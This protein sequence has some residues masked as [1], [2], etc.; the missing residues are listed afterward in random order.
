[1]KDPFDDA[2]LES[3]L[4]YLR[5]T[6]SLDFTGYKRPSLTR[7]IRK[8]IDAVGVDG[9]DEY[10][11]VLESDPDEQA[12]L[13]DTILINVTA[14]FRDEAAW[15]F[16]SAHVV[17]NILAA[18][19]A[20][21]PIRVWSAGCASGEEAYSLAMLLADHLGVEEFKARVKIFATDTDE[22][23]L[24]TARRGVYT[25]RQLEPV[26]PERRARYFEPSPDGFVFRSDC[27]RQVIFGHN[28]ITADAPISRLDLLV[29]RNV[30]MYLLSDTQ[31]HVLDRFSYALKPNGYLFL[32]KAET[33]TAHA[34]LFDPV[35]T[36]LRVF[37]RASTDRPL[38]VPALAE[39]VGSPEM[40][41]DLALA[42]TPVAQLV[43]DVDG[44]VSGANTKARAMFGVS[45]DYLDRP[46]SELEVAH[47]PVELRPYVEQA[48]AERRPVVLR[49]VSRTLADG[50]EQFLE[51]SIAPLSTSAGVDLGVRIAL[52]DVTELGRT[53][54]DL[55]RSTR[56][57]ATAN[58]DLLSMNQ[59]LETS[60]EE[61]QSTNEELETTNE[62]LQS[63]NEELETMNEE[64]QSANDQLQTMNEELLATADQIEAG[65]QFLDAILDGLPDAVA[66][67]DRRL[68]LV[69][70]NRAAEEL[71]GLR[72]DEAI[73]RAFPSLDIGLPVGEISP[74]LHAAVADG[75]GR[76]AEIDGTV[77][78]TL[79]AHDRR[80][81]PFSCR[82]SV[83][84]IGR[85]TPTP[86][87]P[88]V[89]VL[90][91]ASPDG[92]RPAAAS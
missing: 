32:G 53:R 50:H 74:L 58:A 49:D 83:R 80:G 51:I 14:F 73:G 78:V 52:A 40:L 9:F 87:D 18:A 65:Q 38:G 7:R 23:A 69:V 84:R 26:S 36:A 91:E 6:R 63:A 39:R 3:L 4:E 47:R 10:R 1:M 21:E 82:V 42:A 55:E 57:L 27:R 90:M 30:L 2:L 70:W 35:S 29:C 59:Q 44:R 72:T 62:E 20:T 5:D 25:E 11:D 31:R 67:T 64:L 56:D 76:S 79:D 85:P 81:R 41:R 16:L 89:M 13:V 28:D 33:I 46:F 60:N 12:R 22:D 37:Q 77:T 71:F 19:G 66:V 43:L 45:V 34:D 86:T 24:T 48:Y 92:E 61:L 68:D 8:R 75:P 54:V 17:P 88:I 15:D